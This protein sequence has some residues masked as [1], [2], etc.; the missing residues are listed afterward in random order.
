MTEHKPQRSSRGERCRLR[1]FVWGLAVWF[2]L[3]APG[4]SQ[5]AADELAPETESEPD[6]GDDDIDWSAHLRWGLEYDNNPHRREGYDDDGDGLTRYLLG[7][8]LNHDVGSST[9]LEATLRHGGKLFLYESDANALLTEVGAIATWR[10][11]RRVYVQVLADV[12]DRT[13]SAGRRDYIRGGSGVRLGA[14]LGPV[15]PWV[16]GGA[17]FFAFKPAPQSSHRGPRARAGLRWMALDALAVDAAAGRHWRSYA[18]TAWELRDDRFSP[19]GDDVLRSDAYD[20]ASVTA[21][22]RGGFGARLR[23]Q[24]GRNRSNSYGQRLHRHGG[25]L[26]L[27]IPVVWDIFVSA[28]GEIQRTRYEDPVFVDESFLIDEENRN[29][30]SAAVSRR[31]SPSWEVELRYSLHSEEFGVGDDY[32]R[33]V[34]GVGVA[35]YR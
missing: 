22:Y 12:K 1:R 2:A 16:E 11:H 18:T 34:I 28:R 9:S 20:T 26:S 8:E 33:Q 13:E 27:T 15:R 30:L 24:Y 6:D 17:R 5:V 3:L 14:S 31:L 10:A 19:V 4:V 32:S 35:A 23:Y 7:G 21:T 29:R 25:E